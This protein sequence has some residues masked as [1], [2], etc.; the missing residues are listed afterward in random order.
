MPPPSAVDSNNRPGPTV[1][2]NGPSLPSDASEHPEQQQ[3]QDQNQ[4]QQ[5]SDRQ[6]AIGKSPGEVTFFK[7]L[8]AEFKKATHFFD[9][10]EQEFIIRE[11]R[12]REGMQIMKRPNSIMVSEKWSLLARSL[13]R[14]Y[15]DLLLFETFA[16]M[17]YCSFS[18]ILK[19]HD[20]VTGYNTRNAFMSN[21][22]NKANFTSYPRVLAMIRRCEQMYEEVSEKLMS[23][24]KDGLYEDERLFINMIH[25]L[26]E[27]VMDTAEGEG[28]ERT[29]A[30][31]RRSHAMD[32]T[33]S[34]VATLHASRGSSVE[35]NVASSL[36]LLV[37][38]NDKKAKAAQMSDTDDSTYPDRKRSIEESLSGIKRTRR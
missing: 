28:A 19:K 7:L 12:V 13:Y 5:R 9:R 18:K 3:E 32:P 38:E 35:A 23:E 20:K 31:S 6:V 37:E 16:I 17:T 27:Q 11:E 4:E 34:I 14:L 8:H 21:V 10:A 22:V 25:R 33:S 24:G 15:K 29:S 36:R 26:N 1:S 30:A 2:K